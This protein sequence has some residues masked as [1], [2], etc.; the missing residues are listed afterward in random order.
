MTIDTL[1]D[2]FVNNKK[3]FYPDETNI[4]MANKELLNK[5]LKIKEIIK[6]LDGNLKIKYK[7]NDMLEISEDWSKTISL[8]YFNNFLT[9]IFNIE[10]E[11]NGTLILKV[12]KDS[13]I[14]ASLYDE[15]YN[16]YFFLSTRNFRLKEKNV[17]PDIVNK[18]SLIIEPIESF[19]NC[20]YLT[21]CEVPF[22]GKTYL[23]EC[24][25]SFGYIRTLNQ[26]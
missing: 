10:K 19:Y 5:I 12:K 24:P 2:N 8:L 3:V 20:S 26:T 1:V 7:Y 4:D 6:P 15:K 13:K 22:K 17:L 21:A 14:F 11:N 18:E 23:A 25:L 16:L 9:K